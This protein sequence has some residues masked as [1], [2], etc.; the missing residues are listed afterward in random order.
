MLF[1]A[2]LSARGFAFNTAK[3]YISAISFQCKISVSTDTTKHYLVGKL[4]EGFRRSS[5]HKKVRLPITIS[6][7]VTIV[8]A[9]QH[10]TSNTY[11]QKLFAAAFSLAFFGFFRVGELVITKNNGHQ[12]L[13][14]ND[15]HINSDEI[16]VHLRYTKTDQA[17][18]GTQIKIHKRDK[19]VC[20]LQLMTNYLQTRPQCEGPLFCHLDGRP[21]TRNQ[22]SVVLKK[23]LATN[24]IGYK[25]YNTH[26]FRI[27]AATTAAALGYSEETIKLAGRWSSNAYKSYIH[28]L[29][30]A[31]V[32]PRLCQ[33]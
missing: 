19:G 24:D 27:G 31:H 2:S 28:S 32:V 23:A 25:L 9:L 22:F 16:L 33:S 18:K 20:P 12:V 10:V 30:Y 11:E 6:I 26:S 7:L 4:L 15:I 13:K 8:N 3:L 5:Q 1:I 29:P 21:L 14:R 17:G